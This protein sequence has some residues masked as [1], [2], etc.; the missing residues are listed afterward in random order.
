M[1]PVRRLMNPELRNRLFKWRTILRAQELGL[2]LLLLTCFAYFFPRWA[3]WGQN[4]KLDLT[5]A[6]VDQGT[7][8]IDDY[9]HNTGD[10]ALYKGHHY[11]DKAPG[12]AFLGVPFYAVFKAVASSSLLE[13]LMTRLSSNAALTATLQEGGTGL[14]REKVYFAMAL[15]FVTFFTVSIPSAGLG[16]I[17]YH[18]LGR[19]TAKPRLRLLLVLAYALATVAYPF[20]MTLNGRQIVAG[21]TLAAFYLLYR[22][23]R[24]EIGPNALWIVGFLMGWAII[25]DYP[26][27]LILVGLSIYAFFSAPDKRHLIRLV[28]AGIPPVTLAAWYNYRCFDTPLPVGYFYSELYTDLHYTGFLSLS[29]PT[30]SALYGLTFSPFRGL[31]YL[32]PFLVLAMPGFWLMGRDRAHR[33]EFWLCLWTVIS[34]F[35]FNSSSVMWWGGF[36][37]GPAYLVPTVPYLMV[38]IAYVAGRMWQWGWGRL[39][40]GVLL[41]WSWLVTWAETIAGQSFPDLTPNPLLA[42][43]LPRLAAGDIARN[44]GM[45]FHLT[46]FVSLIPLAVVAVFMLSM[47]LRLERSHGDIELVVRSMEPLPEGARRQ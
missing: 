29:F 11:S 42:I 24:R 10:Y 47:L 34:F 25:T 41:A 46:S 15:S 39:A 4:S 20:S 18:F 23:R 6:I 35:W 31:F 26:V 36:S 28:L 2:F 40:F 14:L 3:D 43:S 21:L 37:V 22:Y 19:F 7:F 9:Y 27:G 33:A 38:P 8:V 13:R 32:S 12:T 44:W 5:M 16:V 17:L 30:L 1:W 45:L